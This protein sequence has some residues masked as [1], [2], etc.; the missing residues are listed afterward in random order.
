[1]P[2]SLDTSLPAG[3]KEKEKR[4]RVDYNKLPGQAQTIPSPVSSLKECAQHQIEQLR[5]IAIND[6]TEEED[7]ALQDGFILCDL[8]IIE[9]KLRAW[10]KLFPRV[11]PFFA[12]KCNPD[13]MV[14][15]GTCLS[16][17][18]LAQPIRVGVVV[19]I[20]IIIMNVPIAI[21]I[22]SISLVLSLFTNCFV[23]DC[24]QS[25]DSFS[26]RQDT[27]VRRWQRST[28]RCSPQRTTQPVVFTPTLKRPK[29]TLT[30]HSRWG[31]V[32]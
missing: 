6:R 2:P 26:W 4:V 28:W 22:H 21:C 27:T 7:D 3:V 32:V 9:Q 1:M 11:K 29:P 20:I 23:L 16:C 10:R 14:A 13:P 15:G 24:F 19:G 25:S 12:L 18:Y 5:Q 8:H 17:S 30:R 31:S